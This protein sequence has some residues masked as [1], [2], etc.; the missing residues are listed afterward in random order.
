[1]IVLLTAFEPFDDTGLNASLEG[2][3]TFMARWGDDFDLR[4]LTLPVNYGADTRAVDAALSIESA[5][6][7]L[8]T[9]QAAGS[10]SIRVEKIATNRRYLADHREGFSRG[11][12]PIDAE[13]PESLEATLDTESAAAAVRAAGIPAR[14]STDAGIYL[15]NHVLYRSLQRASRSRAPVRVGFLHIPSLAEQVASTDSFHLEPERTAAAI[16]AVIALQHR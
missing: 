16:H 14:V 1:M 2:C 4:F 13:G 5:D 9:G 15:C 7:I 11:V 3:R 6:L 8:H 10:D 12:S